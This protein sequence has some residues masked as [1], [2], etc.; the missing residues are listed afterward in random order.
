MDCL[1][2]LI[3]FLMVPRGFPKD[4]CG[5]PKDSFVF[6]KDSYGCPKG[7]LRIPIDSSKDSHGFSNG[8]C[9]DSYGSPEGFL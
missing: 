1:R 8:L 5:F 7:F 3:Y 2:I 4:P 9:K 6:P